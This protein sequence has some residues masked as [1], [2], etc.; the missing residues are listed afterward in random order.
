[1]L[2]PTVRRTW[3]P[4]GKTPI[5]RS[6]DRRDRISAI[7]CLTVSPRQGR[8]NFYFDLLADNQTVKAEHTIEFL[9][10]LKKH[11]GGPMT[12][13]WD[14]SS[15]HTK[16]KKVRAYL[17]RHPEIVA[18]TLPGYA[19]ELNPDEGVWGW[20]K[21]GKLANLAAIDTEDLRERT[22]EQFVHLKDNQKLLKSFIR[23][24]GLKLAA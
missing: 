12:V 5:H 17:S 20:T 19:P 2:T 7:S 11:L 9:Q 23:H 22:I 8:I 18:E 1:M 4:A 15:V 13:I 6:F 24:T 3:G 21:Y 16:S 10:N 14:G